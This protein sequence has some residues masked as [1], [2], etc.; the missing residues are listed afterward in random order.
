VPTTGHR[1]RRRCG[2]RAQ[3]LGGRHSRPTP[4]SSR[5]LFET[6]F[7]NNAAG[8]EPRPAGGG[9]T[10][11]AGGRAPRSGFEVLDRRRGIPPEIFRKRARGGDLVSNGARR[12]RRHGAS[13]G[14]VRRSSRER[15]PC[16]SPTG[17]RWPPGPGVLPAGHS[18]R[19]R[20]GRMGLR[21]GE[22]RS[23]YG[24]KARGASCWLVD[25]PM[26]Y[27]RRVL[28]GRDVSMAARVLPWSTGRFVR[29]GDGA[30]GIATGGIRP[31]FAILWGPE[32]R[33]RLGPE[34]IGAA[35]VGP[36]PECRIG[37]ILTD[38]PAFRPRW[39]RS[40][41]APISNL[42][43]GHRRSMH[44][45]ASA[46][47]SF[48]APERIPGRTPGGQP[49]CRFFTA[50]SG[51]TFQRV[52]GRKRRHR[53]S[54]IWTAP[55]FEIAPSH[56]AAKADPSAVRRSNA[57]RVAVTIACK[58]GQHG[59]QKDFRLPDRVDILGRQLLALTAWYTEN[60]T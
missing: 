4:R 25:E 37:Q 15:H 59:R 44:D 19:A 51:N 40:S 8:C 14:H 27:L 39:T 16:R 36:N 34:V 6:C 31:D 1:S 58:P 12:R 46:A 10:G 5:R 33:R 3:S 53:R 45:R 20:N 38:L 48:K 55:G 60:C 35:C 24:T 42:A 21:A 28:G 22:S 43:K 23:G 56:A 50:W 47:R 30:T 2:S 17:R 13:C 32:S 49:P 57:P 54:G 11:R 9:S 52:A 41:W 29:R 26:G 7:N 18:I